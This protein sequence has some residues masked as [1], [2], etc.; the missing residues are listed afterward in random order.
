VKIQSIL[1]H[2]SITNY[3]ND[4]LAIEDCNLN[5]DTGLPL[6]A[7]GYP[8][9]T[10]Q[11]TD[12]GLLLCDNK[13]IGNLVLYGQTIKPIKINTTG[14][15]TF[16]AYL[17][18]PHV[19]KSFFGFSAKELTDTNIDLMSMP[20]ASELNLKEQLLN[21]TLLDKRLQIMNTY[22][23]KLSQRRYSDINKEIAFATQQI[24]KKKGLLSLKDVQSELRI[25]ERSFQRLFESYVGLSPRMFSRISQF[26]SAFQQLNQKQFSNISDIA[27]D[28]GYTDH[29][30]L[31]RIFREFTWSTPSEYL[32]NRSDFLL[33]NQ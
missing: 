19:L 11:S 20:P 22:I 1:P 30:H 28:N 24:Q 14:R 25:T 6:L 13:K 31:T 8:S 23:L 26:H 4:I 12:S 16:I 5:G 9:L 7:N 15:L 29:S 17:L 21:A 32:K 33:L 18:H 27:Y 3:V 2:P 10:F